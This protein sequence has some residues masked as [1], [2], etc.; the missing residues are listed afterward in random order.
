VAEEKKAETYVIDGAVGPGGMPERTFMVLMAIAIG[1]LGGFGAVLFRLA[2]KVSQGAF[3]GTLD[4]TLDYVGRLPWYARFLAPAV[5]GLVVGPVVHYLARETKGHGVPEV[6]ESIVLR[7][8]R[9]R[10]R[11][12]FAKVAASA[13]CI[14]SGGSAG[15]EGPIVQIG[16]SLGS[17]LGQIF[18]VKGLRLRTLVACGAAA[19]IAGTFNA[20][21]AGALFA[22]EVLLG[23]FGVSQFSP[24][25]LSSVA[26]TVVSR[27][28]LGD[29]PA[30]EVPEY[31]FVNVF[32]I[33]AYM[34]LGV[35]AALV[36][37]AFIRTLYAT[38]DLFEKIPLPAVAKPALG[39]LVVGAIGI[40]FPHIFGVGYG[41]ITLALHG[42][43]L[44]T[45]L[46]LMLCL[47]IAATSVTLGSGGSGGV[48]AP[49]LFIG[50]GLGGLV[51]T[52]AHSLFPTLT[53]SPGAYALVGM[54]AVAASGM[55]APLTAIIIVFE[56]TGDYRIILPL[57]VSCV[58]GVLITTRVMR[59]SIYTMKLSRRGVRIVRGQEANILAS[60]KVSQV[61]K[62]EFEAVNES[63][64]IKELVDLVIRSPHINFFVLGDGD[65][66]IGVVSLEDIRNILNQAERL[67]S[68]LVAYDLMSPVVY[69]C[70]PSTTLDKV[71][72]AFGEI[73]TGVEELPVVAEDDPDRLIGVVHKSDVIVAYN[74]EVAKRG[75]VT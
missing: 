31:E 41:A 49:S 60:L 67:G 73:R 68:L 39:G 69:R 53:A 65:R 52:V 14:G 17:T 18:S 32:E 36:A 42:R 62:R 40:Y 26:A 64:S 45:V 9:I 47:K 33:L 72:K 22:V 28:F 66:L 38:E 27:H 59:D 46:A 4:Y 50:A 19:G 13:V 11:V 25:V 58:I 54:G 43:L 44:W 2:I 51:G 56:M 15:R 75:L 24:V 29:F 21:I 57:M 70:K 5:G 20:P 35:A 37:L 7:E 48:F 3:F 74:R 23:D 16:S 61:M 34:V 8:G 12:M 63:A 6:M 71:M 10:P 55:H 1:I 30:F